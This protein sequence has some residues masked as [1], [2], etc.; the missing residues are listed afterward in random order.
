MKTTEDKKGKSIMDHAKEWG[1]FYLF[2]SNIIA[3]GYLLMVRVPNAP[4]WVNYPVALGVGISAVV[5]WAY[6]KR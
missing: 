1:V 3:V 6:N 5:A 4:E 2:L